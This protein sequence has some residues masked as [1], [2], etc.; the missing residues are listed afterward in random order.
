MLTPVSDL[1][2]F[3]DARIPLLAACLSTC[4]DSVSLTCAT[5]R[6]PSALRGLAWTAVSIADN[7]SLAMPAGHDDNA[8]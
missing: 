7:D 6:S 3:R 2:D 8:C 5:R 1:H 4:G